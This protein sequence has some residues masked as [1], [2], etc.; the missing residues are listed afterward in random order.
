MFHVPWKCQIITT[1]CET[2]ALNFCLLCGELSCMWEALS[3]LSQ[4]HISALS[5]E[6]NTA[7][8]DKRQ[9]IVCVWWINTF[10]CWNASG[11]QMCSH[12]I[13]LWLWLHCS[14]FMVLRISA[15]FIRHCFPTREAVFITLIKAG[16]LKGKQAD[17]IKLVFVCLFFAQAFVQ[18]DI[19]CIKM[20]KES[21][22]C[23]V[24]QYVVLQH[25]LLS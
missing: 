25:L 14:D 18:K 16:N 8:P 2:R 6:Q 3:P 13:W 15:Q 5:Q 20:L 22:V 19:L 10:Q 1:V 17:H 9:Y 12:W 11:R 7:V 4:C 24:C 21:C 23:A